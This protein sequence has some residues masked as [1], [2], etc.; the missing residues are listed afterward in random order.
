MA[1]KT[2]LSR[3]I[4]LMLLSILIFTAMDAVAKG[5]VAHY[6]TNQVVFAR[7]AGQFVLVLIL[8][9]RQ[10]PQ[11]FRTRHPALHFWRSAFQLGSAAFFFASLNYIGLAE[12]TA[13]TDINPVLI[14]LG[15]AL[16]LGEKLGPRRIA[17]VICAM[18]G[19]LIVIRPGAGV[20]TLAALLPI[21][22]AL[23]FAANALITR[24]VGAREPVWTP[25]LL[26]ALFG[27]VVTALTLPWAFV[28]PS[29]A[30]IP[31]FLAMAVLGTFGQ[32]CL[33][34][35]FSLAEASVIAPFAYSGIVFA[36]LWG[37]LFY[38]E[39]PDFWTI[40]GALVI[41]SSGL[42]VWHRETRAARRKTA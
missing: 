12:A 11:Y 6:P 22:C 42:Y 2:D 9:N 29:W 36:T 26:A 5:L 25:L 1:P 35:A 37:V 32:L 30:D 34:R 21:G 40:I 27:T 17:A 20:F 33:I 16:F 41:V 4:A 28:M 38:N 3:G 19:A 8:L 13:L 10:A 24:Y 14:T 15:A 7:F 39:Y 23:S 18:V 31:W